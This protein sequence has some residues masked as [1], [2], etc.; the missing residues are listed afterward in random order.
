M[1]TKENLKEC[2]LSL[3]ES[4]NNNI[5]MYYISPIIEPFYSNQDLGWGTMHIRFTVNQGKITPCTIYKEQEVNM[6]K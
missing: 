1:V 6:M 5:D 4:I 2:V 3:S